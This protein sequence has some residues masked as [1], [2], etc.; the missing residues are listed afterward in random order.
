MIWAEPIEE[1]VSSRT[2][3]GLAL[4]RHAAAIATQVG[5]AGEGIVNPEYRERAEANAHIATLLIARWLIT[6]LGASR[7]EMDWLGQL[8]ERSASVMRPMAAVARGYFVWRDATIAV[9]RDEGRSMGVAIGLLR[10][11]TDAVRRSCDVSLIRTARAYD[12]QMALLYERLR[13]QS[14]HD[15]LTELP[16]RRLFDD[17]LGEMVREPSEPGGL[18][19][20][21]LDLDG[22]K[23]INDVFGHHAGDEVLREV[24]ARISTTVRSSDTIARMGGDEF[25]ALLPGAGSE[26]AAR[27]AATKLQRCLKAPFRLEG[28]QV[29]IGVSIGIAF[30]NAPGESPDVLVRRADTA[31]YRAKQQRSGIST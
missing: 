29:R 18:A 8:G 1:G 14:L 17:R 9:L 3:L 25:V 5:Q 16:N 11:V 28:R 27:R 10:E 26:E 23:K 30:A 7:E 15:P 4:G 20:L 6:G 2:A 24:G 31:M 13:H 19:V 21:L 22:F 12:R